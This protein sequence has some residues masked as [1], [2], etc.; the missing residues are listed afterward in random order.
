M[1][2]YFCEDPKLDLCMQLDLFGFVCLDAVEHRDLT[3]DN[4]NL[5][6]MRSY[7][8]IY[9]KTSVSLL[10]CSFS[11]FL[12]PFCTPPNFKSTLPLRASQCC[13]LIQAESTCTPMQGLD[14]KGKKSARGIKAW[15][16]LYR[17]QNVFTDLY[18]CKVIHILLATP[19]LRKARSTAATLPGKV[20]PP[21]TKTLS[22]LSPS[23]SVMPI[24]VL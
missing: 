1:I 21:I 24:R 15:C 10:A 11:H 9:L 16:F 4:Y 22:A 18:R 19:E 6:K 14:H 20:G 13:L 12:H 5:G 3:L 8:D 23:R 17:Q 7:P 2:L